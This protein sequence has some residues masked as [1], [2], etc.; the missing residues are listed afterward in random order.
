MSN[1]GKAINGRL[2][3]ERNK[4]VWLLKDKEGNLIDS[5]R[6]KAVAE[7]IKN[8]KERELFIELVLERDNSIKNNLINLKKNKK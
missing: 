8:E 7:K 4:E 6:Q 1:K 2:S 3:E 5:F